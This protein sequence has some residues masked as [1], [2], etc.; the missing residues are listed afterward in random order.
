MDVSLR[1]AD[2]VAAEHHRWLLIEA[3]RERR[4]GGCAP[5]LR[6]KSIPKRAVTR[7]VGAVLA[8]AAGRV[9]LTLWAP[10]PVGCAVAVRAIA[11]DA[12]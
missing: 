11:P 3:E 8:G 5:R 10:A 4:A 7:A 6:T 2:V 1:A 12:G 9:G